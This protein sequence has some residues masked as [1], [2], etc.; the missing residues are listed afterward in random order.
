MD[1]VAEVGARLTDE[2]CTTV[3]LNG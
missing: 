3:W 1:F 2:N